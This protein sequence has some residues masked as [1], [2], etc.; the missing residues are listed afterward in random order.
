[1][2]HIDP[3]EFPIRTQS[4]FCSFYLG[5]D[6]QQAGSPQFNSDFSPG[7]GYLWNVHPF[8]GTGGWVDRNGD[9]VNVDCN[10]GLYGVGGSSQDFGRNWNSQFALKAERDPRRYL[11]EGSRFYECSMFVPAVGAVLTCDRT[12]PVDVS[13]LSWHLSGFSNMD[14]STESRAK[15]YVRFAAVNMNTRQVYWDAHTVTEESYFTF[16]DNW[17]AE[18]RGDAYPISPGVTG[19]PPVSTPV[20]GV[21]SH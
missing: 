2:Y 5:R 3:F 14:P 10:S 8:G 11:V 21:G 13:Q 4:R 18:L 7:A 17:S 15:R 6:S 16:P 9:P 12:A 20:K 1:M 19:V